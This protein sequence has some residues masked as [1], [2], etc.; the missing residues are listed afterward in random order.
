MILS[1]K[2]VWT[3]HGSNIR[4]HFDPQVSRLQRSELSGGQISVHECQTAYGTTIF[5]ML[6]MLSMIA[7]RKN[8]SIGSVSWKVFYAFN[9]S[10]IFF[11]YCLSIEFT[12]NI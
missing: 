4:V 6:K 12:L 11:F 1:V 5:E 8:K 10:E 7:E 3:T 9:A 2:T